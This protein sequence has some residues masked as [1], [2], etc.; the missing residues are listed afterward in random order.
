MP[1]EGALN[2]DGLD[3][4]DEQLTELFNVDADTWLAEADLT[5]EYFAQ[6]GDRLPAEMTAQLAALRSRLQS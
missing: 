1:L 5:E 4:S 6:F 2:V 3:I